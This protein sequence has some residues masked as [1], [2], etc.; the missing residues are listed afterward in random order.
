MSVVVPVAADWLSLRETADG[1]ARSAALADAAVRGIRR[2]PVVVHDLGGGTGSMAR[3]LAPRIA[4]PQTWVLHDWNAELLETATAAELV[5]G[6]GRAVALRA[7]VGDLARLDAAALAGA[8]LV[9]ASALLDV[10]TG[11][12]L[13]AVVD[14]C[15]GAGAP[16]LFSLSVT[17]RVDLRPVDPAD[18]VIEQAFNDHQRRTAHGRTLLGPDAGAAAARLFADRGWRVRTAQ[19]PW[20]L[21]A[22]DERLVREWLDGWLDA[23]V[24]QRPALREWADELRRRRGVQLADGS[25]RVTVRHLDLLAGPA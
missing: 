7:R 25:L 2:H 4:A 23:A 10:L 24:E 16:A 13:T 20:R 14:A 6:D 17:G 18:R 5:G 3:W 9:T 21:G 19:T 22:G 8:S 11:P 15:V 1:R 12:E